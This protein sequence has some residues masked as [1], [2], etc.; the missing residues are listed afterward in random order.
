MMCI[1]WKPTI[2]FKIAWYLYSRH[3]WQYSL[4]YATF[5]EQERIELMVNGKDH[6]KKSMEFYLD[7][8]SS[9]SSKATGRFRF[10]LD[11]GSSKF[12]SSCNFNS[13]YKFYDVMISSSRFRPETNSYCELR[14]LYISSKSR[15]FSALLFGMLYS[16]LSRVKHSLA[17]KDVEIFLGSFCTRVE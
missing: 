12:H 17:S 16:R 13:P 9:I 3:I 6:R 14:A 8:I 2:L 4:R 15:P 7:I 11:I 5:K 10:E 1:Y